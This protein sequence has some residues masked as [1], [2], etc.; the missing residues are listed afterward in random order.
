MVDRSPIIVF[1]EVLSVQPGPAGASPTTEY[2]FAVEEVLK[3]FVAGSGIMV[4]QPGGIS[5]DG[6]AM[7][8]LGLPMLDEGNRVLLFLHPDEN[9]AHSIVEYGLG[10]FFEVRMGDRV[11]LLREPS[12]QG[13]PPLPGGR[14]GSGRD[15]HSGYREVAAFRHWIADRTAGVQRASDYFA[16]ELPEGPTAVAS[17]FR[18]TQFC[19]HTGSLPSRWRG[20]RP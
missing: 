6:T 14:A 15:S 5:V 16:A 19:D 3:G 8:I 1:G 7:S 13:A 18:L 10:M 20:V 17:P 2:L 11:F 4:R 12:L 9:G